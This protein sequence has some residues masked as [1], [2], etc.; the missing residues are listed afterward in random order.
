MG[1]QGVYPFWV[2]VAKFL[3]R[4]GMVWDRLGAGG[5]GVH[6]PPPHAEVCSPEVPTLRPYEFLKGLIRQFGDF[7]VEPQFVAQM[8][9]AG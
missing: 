2:G 1:G 5:G 3:V 6:I 8:T 7:V 4:C 9:Q